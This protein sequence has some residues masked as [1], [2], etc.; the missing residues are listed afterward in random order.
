[1]VEAHETLDMRL[2]FETWAAR[3]VWLT[4]EM[5]TRLRVM[6]L[7]APSEAAEFLDPQTHTGLT[8]FRLR[9]GLFVARRPV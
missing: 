9:E 3:S 4:P 8:T 6:L 5:L 7:R 1:M 2:T